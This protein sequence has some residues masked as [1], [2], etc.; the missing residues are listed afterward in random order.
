MSLRK[1]D[2]LYLHYLDRELRN[3]VSCSVTEVEM[4]RA[5]LASFS[6]TPGRLFCSYSHL[7]ESHSI[8]TQSLGL[9][10]DAVAADL[11]FPASNHPSSEEFLD[12]RHQ[13]YAHDAKRYPLYFKRKKSKEL[14]KIQPSFSTLSSATESLDRDLRS[15]IAPSSEL[16]PNN[17]P[18]QLIDTGLTNRGDKAIT[19]SL[20]EPHA[21][22][23]A[24]SITFI[25]RTISKS[26]TRHYMKECDAD[27]LTSIPRLGHFDELANSFPI[28]DAALFNCL[29]SSCYGVP[30]SPDEL[31]RLI[32]HAIEHHGSP[33]HTAFLTQFERVVTDSA[34][35]VAAHEFL[36]P[37]PTVGKLIGDLKRRADTA[38]V[39]R[40][41]KFSFEAFGSVLLRI[42]KA[43][44]RGTGEPNQLVTNVH[45]YFMGDIYK[46]GQ[47]A[48]VGPGAQG[49]VTNQQYA[50]NQSSIHLQ[51]LTADLDRVLTQIKAGQEGI[52]E[53][54][55]NAL[56]DARAA[57]ETKDP[58]K[59]KA[60]F[61][62][63][64]KG[65]YSFAE[66]VGASL[67]ASYVKDGMGLGT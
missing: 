66:K 50:D 61:A 55:V 46:V 25:R 15:L 8:L 60:C 65:V 31:G 3:A 59:V 51:Q 5:L 36:R 64:G 42:E 12:A 32:E 43:G 19:G 20:F 2:N 38:S 13:L 1:T 6:L 54:D 48:A 22:G 29:L 11:L 67:V 33:E 62:K 16:S 40:I 9:L 24:G 39:A 52:T 23:D 56:Q 63:V 37:V 14:R 30:H 45:N 27:I 21:A 57:A 17:I 49:H 26:Y 4:L 53:T 35:R 41:S 10:R 18:V 7:W 28:Y 47:A 58:G 34:Q 44:A